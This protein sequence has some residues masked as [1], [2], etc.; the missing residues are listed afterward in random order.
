MP[1]RRGQERRRVYHQPGAEQPVAA[2]H[3]AAAGR[4]RHHSLQ[5]H[6]TA[7]S[8]ETVGR[9]QREDQRRRTGPDVLHPH[10]NQ[11]EN[12]RYLRQIHQ[13]RIIKSKKMLEMNNNNK[14]KS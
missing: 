11:P 2:G 7:A 8:V 12:G 14:K 1:Q 10:A 3:P 6:V 13:K 5:S 9:R 4:Q